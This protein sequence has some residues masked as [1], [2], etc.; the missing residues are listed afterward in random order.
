M[1]TGALES[2]AW[3][4]EL[5]NGP[6]GGAQGSGSEES[7]TGRGEFIASPRQVELAL[8]NPSVRFE[9]QVEGAVVSW[10]KRGW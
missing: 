2:Y 7:R 8:F 9:G 4:G 1:A 3:V 6:T 10:G 5:R